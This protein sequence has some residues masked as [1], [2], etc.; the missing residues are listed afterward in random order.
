M[1]R[2]AWYAV[3]RSAVLQEA[4]LTVRALGEQFVLWRSPQ[5]TVQAMADQCPHRGAQLSR[6]WLTAG[7][8][9][10][11]YHGWQFNTAGKCV[12]IPANQAE[13]TIPK[14]AQIKTYATTERYGLV[15]LYW[16]DLPAAQGIPIPPL[17][18]WGAP[19]WRAIYGESEW[20]AHFTRVTEGNMDSS[21]APFVHSAF[22]GLR[23]GAQVPPYTV[24]TTPWSVSAI[25]ISK[26]PKRAGILKLILK[27]DRPVT[28][29]HL[30]G[31]LPGV[32]RI[33]VDFKFKGYRFIYFGVHTP[34]DEATTRTQWIGLRNFLT[35]PW[36]DGH[37]RRNVVKTFEEDCAVIA[38]VRPAIVPFQG[39]TEVLVGSDA[40]QV[41]YRKLLRQY[42]Q[43]G[44]WWSDRYPSPRQPTLV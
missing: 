1:L 17:P 4:P 28:T 13:A 16:G 7:C 43:Q 31:Y 42:A 15:W 14:R 36:A 12:H 30:T 20:P 27:R 38:S 33:D 2:N 9:T 40:L 19:G 44:W 32:N 35:A 23:D 11:P 3:T 21:H 10:C 24:E 41:A 5:G 39:G 22:F 29:A 25:T 8:L 34:V 37:S 26:P 6:G 18:E